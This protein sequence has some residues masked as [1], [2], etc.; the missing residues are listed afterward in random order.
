MCLHQSCDCIGPNTANIF[1]FSADASGNV[2]HNDGGAPLQLD[3]PIVLCGRS[4]N[5]T[6]RGYNGRL[7]Q[8]ALFDTALS[9]LQVFYIYKQVLPWRS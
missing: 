9:P 5:D 8:L 7:T 2:L 1:L 6:L 4:D 3:G